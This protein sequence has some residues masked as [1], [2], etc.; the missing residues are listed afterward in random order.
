MLK[1]PYVPSFQQLHTKHGLQGL[2]EE[3]YRERTILKA[4]VMV[5]K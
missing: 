5:P 2:Q 1:L 3:N 4:V